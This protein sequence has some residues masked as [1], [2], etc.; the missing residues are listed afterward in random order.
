MAY[1]F[2]TKYLGP[3]PEEYELGLSVVRILFIIAIAWVADRLFR[4]RGFWEWGF[5]LSRG[6]LAKTADDAL[7]LL[8]VGGAIPLLLTF[9][10]SL[11][12]PLPDHL[13]WTGLFVPVLSQEVFLLGF[14]QGRLSDQLKTKFIVLIITTLFIAAHLNHSTQGVVGI[15]FLGAMG[16]QGLIWSIYRSKELSIVAPLMA[17]LVLLILYF[18][19]IQGFMLLLI[20]GLRGKT[21]QR[22]MEIVRAT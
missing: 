9:F 6:S 2:V 8:L 20:I 17:H 7:V 18:Y 12:K 14:Y 3:V 10:G 11:N 21:W 13:H 22:F 15:F 4:K 16:W 19:P 1:R 5:K